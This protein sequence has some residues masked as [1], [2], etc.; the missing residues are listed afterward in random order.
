MICPTLTVVV[1]C[2]SAGV[3]T[4]SAWGDADDEVVEEI[5]GEVTIAV[6][7]TVGAGVDEGIADG[8]RV[9]ADVGDELH[10]PSTSASKNPSTMNQL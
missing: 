4:M 10:A 6:D 8:V 5:T 9:G 3:S 2:W 7:A 1:C